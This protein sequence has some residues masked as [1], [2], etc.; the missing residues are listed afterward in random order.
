MK[1]QKIL[2]LITAFAFSQGSMAEMSHKK[3]TGTKHQHSVQ[4]QKNVRGQVTVKVK[5]MVCSFCAQGIEKNFGQHKSV[6]STKVDL[7]KMEVTIDLKPGASLSE[8]EIAK[9]IVDAGFSYEGIKK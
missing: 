1:N 8:K 9:I 5:G 3:N 6:K 2:S 7:D 4:I